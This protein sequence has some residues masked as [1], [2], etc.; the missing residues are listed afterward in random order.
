MRPRVYITQPVA[1]SAIERLQQ[2]ADVDWNR[3]AL[4]IATKQELLEAA[5][6][7][8]VVFCLLHDR[9]DRD[10]INANPKL[11]MIAS[12]TI[13]PADIDI[14]AATERRIPVTTVPSP[15]LDDSTADL[16]WALMLAV[17]R[18][19]A[20]GDRLIR[21]GVIPGSQ[22]SYLEGGGV[23][24]R[25]LGIL[26]MGGVGREAARRA[27]G[28]RMKVIYHDPKRLPEDEE[29][30]LGFTWVPFD[31]LFRDADFVSVHVAL[32][33]KTRHLVGA[34]EFALMKPA[35]YFINTARGPIVHEE[36]LIEALQSKRI[37]G[38]GLDVYEREPDIDARLVALP[39]VVMTPHTGSADRELR[40]AMA[41]VAVD[42]ILAVLAGREPPNCWNREIYA[43]K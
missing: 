31:Q 21:S 10:I 26:G 43:G 6:T 14:A 12:T 28:F 39:N 16:A 1:M 37:A 42:N 34:R 23:S 7:H 15:L 22:S 29:R 17:S 25:T 38:A 5:R 4:H 27:A 9:I 35:A 36:A 41:N 33:P 18:R 40:S 30:A 11:K 13:T 8:D 32:N 19:V 3:D 20:E 2:V 24:R